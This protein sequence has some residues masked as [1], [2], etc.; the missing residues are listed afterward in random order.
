MHVAKN[1]PYVYS[2]VWNRNNNITSRIEIVAHRIDRFIHFHNQVV[3]RRCK[4]DPTTGATVLQS[5]SNI[6]RTTD[7]SSLLHAF[8]ASRRISRRG[9]FILSFA[10]RMKRFCRIVLYG[11]S[12]V[13]F[14]SSLRKRRNKNDQSHPYHLTVNVY[15]VIIMTCWDEKSKTMFLCC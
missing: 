12:F 3:V 13:I 4:S 14:T 15:A 11:F 8:A 9:P 2:T 5:T 7:F 6:P 10:A 1:R